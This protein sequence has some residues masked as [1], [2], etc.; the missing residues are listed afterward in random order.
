MRLSYQTFSMLTQL[1]RKETHF[2][3]QLKGPTYKAQHSCNI[4]AVTPS[5]KDATLSHR[6]VFRWERHENSWKVCWQISGRSD[7]TSAEWLTHWKDQLHTA[8]LYS[9]HRT[10]KTLLMVSVYNHQQIISANCFWWIAHHLWDVSWQHS[11][12][13]GAPLLAQHFK[14]R[15]KTHFVKRIWPK[16][17]TFWHRAEIHD[18]SPAAWDWCILQNR[19]DFSTVTRFTNYRTLLG[20]NGDLL[21]SS[22]NLHV[23]RSLFFTQLHKRITL[24]FISRC[25]CFL[26]NDNTS[27]VVCFEGTL[28]CMAYLAALMRS[29]FHLLNPAFMLIKVSL[30]FAEFVAVSHYWEMIIYRPLVCEDHH[31][32]HHFNHW[33][34]YFMCRLVQLHWKVPQDFVFCSSCW[35]CS[36]AVVLNMGSEPNEGVAR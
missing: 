1:C 12:F 24:N 3:K 33:V 29:H 4:T 6:G 20:K 26:Q 15:A 11:P 7:P 22:Y 14:H 17:R 31:Y 13:S 30:V 2:A 9:L 19:E 18:V 25:P 21:L 10:F 27:S 36:R 28:N 8:L 23:Q 5:R 16:G 35:I 32:R 34:D